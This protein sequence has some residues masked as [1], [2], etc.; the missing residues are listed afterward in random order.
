MPTLAYCLL[1][2]LMS[3]DISIILKSF[4]SLQMTL[5]TFPNFYDTYIRVHPHSRWLIILTRKNYSNAY[6]LSYLFSYDSK[7]HINACE[8]FCFFCHYSLHIAL[9]HSRHLWHFII[10]ML[11]L[12]VTCI[13]ILK[14]CVI[15][16]Q[17]KMLLLNKIST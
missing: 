17:M 6:S 5:Q 14:V 3:T 13:L 7:R 15:I 16:L 2:T 12:I 8:H 1:F 4:Q 9:I 11:W 10:V